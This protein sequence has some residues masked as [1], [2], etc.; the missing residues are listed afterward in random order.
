MF[1][2]RLEIDHHEF[3]EVHPIPP[4]QVGP[5]AR[6]HERGNLNTPRMMYVEAIVQEWRAFRRH[7]V[8]SA[9]QRSHPDPLQYGQVARTSGLERVRM[10]RVGPRA[11]RE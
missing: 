11:R 10:G 9:S 5:Q 3:L 8:P 2:E 1:L 6:H 4:V 7:K